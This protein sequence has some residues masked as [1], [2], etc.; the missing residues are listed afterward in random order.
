VAG[1]RVS[2]G[3][4]EPAVEP[5]LAIARRIVERY[6]RERPIARVQRLVGSA[7]GRVFELQP[8]DRSASLVLKL[9]DPDASWQVEQ[10]A[11]VFEL[12]SRAGIPVP[13]VLLTDASRALI[14]AD[15]MLMSKLGGSIVGAL[16]L[17]AEDARE[18][19]RSIGATLRTIHSIT[20]KHFGFFNRS[21]AVDPYATNRDFMR[22][23]FDRDLARFSEAAGP[24][25]LRAA[26]E[27]RIAAGALAIAGC[28]GSALCHGDL[29]EANVLMQRASSGW[30]V[31]GVVDVG[32]AIAA[33]PLF[34]LARTDYWST[35]GDPEKRAGLREGYGEPLR[36]DQEAA[37]DIY[38]LHHALELWNWFARADDGRPIVQ[39]I[40][41]DL[42]R[43]AAP[44]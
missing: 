23:W 10:E 31:T 32:G 42:E 34:D 11:L 20:F 25:S 18:I 37:I 30:V 6:D 2:A 36:A 9:F 1:T 39:E 41:A 40:T 17:S 33:D 7:R 38:A 5:S 27:R 21:G 22:A 24:S 14:D 15:W 8:T 16:D 43:L 12:L 35:R 13:D 29:H 19:Y 4:L 3:Y 44:S 26:I 28:G